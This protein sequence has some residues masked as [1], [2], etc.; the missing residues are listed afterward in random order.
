MSPKTKNTPKWF[1]Y[2]ALQLNILE[3]N[4]EKVNIS[5]KN[6]NKY[7]NANTTSLKLIKSRIFLYKAMEEHNT[8]NSDIEFKDINT[9]LKFDPSFAPAIVLKAK[10]L[11]KKIKS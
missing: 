1:F 8:E 9:S 5:I 7:T 4:W 11:Y 6:I 3:K 10:L 2:T